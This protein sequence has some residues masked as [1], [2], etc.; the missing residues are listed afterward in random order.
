MVGGAASAQEWDMNIGGFFT[1]DIMFSESSGNFLNAATDFDGAVINTNAEILFRPSITLD[2]GMTFG[3]VVELEG[4]TSGDQ[5]DESYMYVE[6]DSMGRVELGSENSVGYKMMTGAPSVGFGI[7][8]PSNSAFLPI[9]PTLLSGGQALVR[10]A[11]GNTSTEVAG[12]NDAQRISYYTPS[13]NG[14]SLGVSYAPGTAQGN[15]QTDRNGGV[16]DIFDIAANYSQSFGNVDMTLS[17]RWGTGDAGT[18]FNVV[19]NGIDGVAGTGD[20]ILAPSLVQQDD[21]ETW[22]IGAQF[23]FGAFTVGAAYAENDAGNV[24]PVTVGGNTVGFA[25]GAGD[26]EGYHVGVTYALDNA[27]TVGADMYQGEID[28][29]TTTTGFSS[30]SEYNAF[31]IGASRSLGSGVTWRIYAIQ[32][33]VNRSTNNPAGFGAGTVPVLKQ[34]VEST[35]IGTGIAL[36]F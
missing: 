9:S 3:A 22:G 33:E 10:N 34:K 12:N 25:D 16:S 15:G 8:S 13:F 36:T 4:N 31:Q 21:P 1:G 5:I 17:A 24:I 11:Y 29:G 6:S 14:L 30:K 28:L 7:A 19:N 27:W 23:G 26:S 2:N 18:A 35:T 20:D 32:A